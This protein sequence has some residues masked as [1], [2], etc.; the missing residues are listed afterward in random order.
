[1]VKIFLRITSRE[2]RGG[3]EGEVIVDNLEKNKN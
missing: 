1:M 3:G 2:G